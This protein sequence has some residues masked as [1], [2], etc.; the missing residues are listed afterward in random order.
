MVTGKRKK[1]EGDAEEKNSKK[2]KKSSNSDIKQP[3]LVQKEETIDHFKVALENDATLKSNAQSQKD[4]LKTLRHFRKDDSSNLTSNVKLEDNASIGN[5]TEIKKENDDCSSS[6]EKLNHFR[7]IISHNNILIKPVAAVAPFLENSVLSTPRSDSQSN[8]D[9]KDKCFISN[10]DHNH[11]LPSLNSIRRSEVVFDKPSALRDIPSSSQLSSYSTVQSNFSSSSHKLAPTVYSQSNLLTPSSN[12][13]LSR[14]SSST[15]DVNIQENNVYS[16]V[17]MKQLIFVQDRVTGKYFPQNS[18]YISPSGDE[19]SPDWAGYNTSTNPSY[20]VV[21][22]S[23]INL[24]VV[25][26]APVMSSQ[27]IVQSEQDFRKA[28]SRPLAHVLPLSETTCRSEDDLFTQKHELSVG[29]HSEVE[30][31]FSE[32]DG[33]LRNSI[34]RYF[35]TTN[36]VSCKDGKY[37]DL[38]KQEKESTEEKLSLVEFSN[39]LCSSETNTKLPAVDHINLKDCVP[40][41]S[42][43]SSICDNIPL[44]FDTKLDMPTDESMV[45]KKF[46]S[47][48]EPTSSYQ[49]LNTQ[50]NDINMVHIDSIS[51]SEFVQRM[52]SGDSSIPT[53]EFIMTSSCDSSISTGEFIM[54]SCD[55]SI[56]AG[57]FIA[58]ANVHERNLDPGYLKVNETMNTT[59]NNLDFQTTEVHRVSLD[60]SPIEYKSYDSLCTFSFDD[61]SNN[62]SSAKE[63]MKYLQSLSENVKSVYCSAENNNL[64]NHVSI[65]RISDYEEFQSV[66]KNQCNLKGNYDNVGD[67]CINNSAFESKKLSLASEKRCVQ[68]IDECNPELSQESVNKINLNPSEFCRKSSFYKNDATQKQ[69]GKLHSTERVVGNL[70]MNLIKN[71]MSL[72]LQQMHNYQKYVKL[73]TIKQET[74]NSSVLKSV[75]CDQNNI[76]NKFWYKKPELTE[77]ESEE[78]L[79]ELPDESEAY[80]QVSES[81]LY[82]I[83]LNKPE[84]VVPSIFLDKNCHPSEISQ[85]KIESAKSAKVECV[86]PSGK[87][88][89]DLSSCVKK[90]PKEHSEKVIA[91][92]TLNNMFSSRESENL[93][94]LVIVSVKG[95]WFMSDNQQT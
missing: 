15:S 39:S 71:P 62:I 44:S 7:K 4:F 3:P 93:P 18:A 83:K 78:E 88:S 69:L 34:D 84:F 58:D 63:Q 77:D 33:K 30:N 9:N 45:D 26:N 32:C 40:T 43:C 64:E 65:D 53:G 10:K 60:N 19:T 85:D 25:Y 8:E 73:N 17:A 82:D 54:A 91:Q 74:S 81:G 72:P 80:N 49:N 27:P 38:C 21:N 47:A 79:I 68:S 95:K 16:P 56:P 28:G 66:S 29:Q 23:N 6:K 11:L 24:P 94:A 31:R 92:N 75:Q 61:L 1:T 76:P 86:K 42:S 59:E 55:S 52:D 70:D 89:S 41:N 2:R 36:P 35:E 48:K 14:S 67:I 90:K 13:V 22:S 37:L 87:S 5:V 50:G 12:C 20:Y 46:F 57:E 51:G